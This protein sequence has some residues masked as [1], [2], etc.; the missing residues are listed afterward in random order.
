MA[1][2]KETPQIDTAGQD[3]PQVPMAS[4]GQSLGEE[5]TD[6]LYIGPKPESAPSE[7][8]EPAAESSENAPLEMVQAPALDVGAASDP[9][10]SK[11]ART[12]APPAE[13]TNTLIGTWVPNPDLPWPLPPGEIPK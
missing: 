4:S 5:G 3:V 1:K 12:Q 10:A 9:R 11:T 13:T 8:P 2:K 7:H 6:F